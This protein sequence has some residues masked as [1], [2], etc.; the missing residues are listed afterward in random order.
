MG[1]LADRC[2]VSQASNCPA[3]PQSWQLM[4]SVAQAATPRV[5]SRPASEQMQPALPSD[6]L[7]NLALSLPLAT[8][9]TLSIA[10]C[11]LQLRP[12]CSAR[13]LSPA[14]ACPGLRVLRGP[15]L[16]GRP[17][18]PQWL[19]AP[20]ST[21]HSSPERLQGPCPLPGLCTLL[22]EAVL[23]HLK[24]SKC[25]AY[26]TSPSGSRLMYIK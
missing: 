8:Q 19:P 17:P 13:D 23:T 16:H 18:Q 12:L 14:Q 21:G 1:G 11:F 24:I 9:A 15:A 5:A 7:Q 6:H 25:P 22:R 2:Q 26:L 20:P 10:R 4:A 3:P